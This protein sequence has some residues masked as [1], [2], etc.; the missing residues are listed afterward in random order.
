MLSTKFVPTVAVAANFKAV[1]GHVIL[2]CK[3]PGVSCI[4][5]KGLKETW[6]K[7][8]TPKLNKFY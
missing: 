1:S 7:K 5:T 6:K 8:N 3:I 2:G 4:Y